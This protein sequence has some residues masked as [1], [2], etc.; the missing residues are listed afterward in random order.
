MSLC[1]WIIEHTLSWAARFKRLARDYERAAASHAP[2]C[3][4]GGT[5]KAKYLMS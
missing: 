3:T 2:G 5:S 4:L 1:R